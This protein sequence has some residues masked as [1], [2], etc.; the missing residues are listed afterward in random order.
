MQI[1]N[2]LDLQI[3][4]LLEVGESLVCDGT[5]IIRVYDAKGK[6]RESLKLEHLPPTMNI[7]SHSILFDADFSSDSEL[8][9]GFQLKGMSGST[10]VAEVNP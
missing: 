2:Y 3:P 1:D 6:P 4:V 9:L 7:G 5:S 10:I 8:K